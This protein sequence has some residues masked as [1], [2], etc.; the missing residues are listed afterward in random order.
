MLHSTTAKRLVLMKVIIIS[1]I[2]CERICISIRALFNYEIF[3]ADEKGEI[4]EREIQTLISGR[5]DLETSSNSEQI[6]SIVKDTF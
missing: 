5:S 6:I 2:L 4:L 3:Q 1:R